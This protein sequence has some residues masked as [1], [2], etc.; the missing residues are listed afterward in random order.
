MKTLM[1]VCGILGFRVRVPVLKT[2][3]NARYMDIRLHGF[4]LVQTVRA[5]N[6]EL[7]DVI[8]LAILLKSSIPKQL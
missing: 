7:L 4:W 6:N 2:R 5:R 8:C 3:S 1:R